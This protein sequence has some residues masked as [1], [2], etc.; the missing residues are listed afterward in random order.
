MLPGRLSESL[1]RPGVCEIRPD[2]Y[3]DI[4]HNE[5][6]CVKESEREIDRER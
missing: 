3:Q 6:K 1:I 4:K 2:P 5:K